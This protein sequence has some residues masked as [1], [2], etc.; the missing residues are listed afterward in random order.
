[1]AKKLRAIIVIL[2]AVGLTY[3][4]LKSSEWDLVGL[5]LSNVKRWPLFFG[6][7]VINLTLVIRSLRW[8]VLLAPIAQ[9]K[10]DNVIAATAI[11]FGSLFVVGRASEVIR[12]IVL[13]LRENLK[14]S[15]TLATI[16]IERI[17]D[18][19]AVVSIFAINL[20]FFTLPVQDAERLQQLAAIRWVGLIMLTGLVIG[21]FLLVAL[22]MKA[23]QLIGWLEN[24]TT[25]FS[26]QL[27][28]PLLNLIRHLA[29]GLAVLVS[30]RALT[31][32]L[33]YTGVVWALVTTATWLVL[34]AFG[35]QLSLSNVIFVLGF[36][37]IGSLVP[38]PGGSA[39]AFH[40]TAA[41]G[42]E[43]LGIE[44]NLA[45]AIAI[46]Y[47]LIAFG[48]PL[49]VGLFYLIRDGIRLSQLRAML[50]Q[51]MTVNTNEANP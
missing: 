9:V 39:G 21:I 34:Y 16:L 26:L 47:H 8:Q 42:F 13:S 35:Q 27:L 23:T 14:P 5:Y 12:P 30:V 45:A 2:L 24:L 41:K 18:T 17:Y 28:Q 10:L 15:A 38:T 33:L 50:A 29:D 51:E 7:L 22:R 43:F 36:G 32:S 25:R 4:F 3:W 40:A 49:L 6:F 11:G 1:M 48:S 37:L 19:T 31:L 46:V 20:L 44:H